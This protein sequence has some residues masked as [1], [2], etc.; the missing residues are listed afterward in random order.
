MKALTARL[1]E[2]A[3]VP[4]KDEQKD[5]L[6]PLRLARRIDLSDYD[7]RLAK[8]VVSN[9]KRRNKGLKEL[10]SSDSPDAEK[11]AIALGKYLASLRNIRVPDELRSYGLTEDFIRSLEY[12]MAK[13][14]VPL[15]TPIPKDWSVEELRA[16]CDAVAVNC[17]WYLAIALKAKGVPIR[18]NLTKSSS[19][20]YISN[21]LMEV[22]NG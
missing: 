10:L 7:N 13:K 15:G 4:T 1:Q 9:A 11:A 20:K 16:F 8:R 3:A 5:S 21:L 2:L 14:A 19:V 12:A 18:K 17:V 22:Y 6:S